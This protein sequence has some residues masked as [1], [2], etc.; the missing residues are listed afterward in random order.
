MGLFIACIV[1]GFGFSIAAHVIAYAPGEI[2]DIFSLGAFITAMLL[3]SSILV[4][5]FLNGVLGEYEVHE[6]TEIEDT[7]IF[8]DGQFYYTPTEE[9]KGMGNLSAGSVNVIDGEGLLT[10]RRKIGPRWLVYDWTAPSD[11]ILEVREVKH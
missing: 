3:A 2:G 7:V 11:Y 1:I 8:S 10:E 9:L 5:L 4:S 6:V